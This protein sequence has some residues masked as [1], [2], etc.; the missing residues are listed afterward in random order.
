MIYVMYTPGCQY[1]QDFGDHGPGDH[2]LHGGGNSVQGH[3]PVL[4]CPNVG[5]LL[6]QGLTATI[7]STTLGKRCCGEINRNCR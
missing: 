5:S 4:P 3:P 6:P 1:R 2:D 7:R